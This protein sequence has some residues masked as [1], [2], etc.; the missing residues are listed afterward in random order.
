MGRVKEIQTV[1]DN[2]THDMVAI[3][4]CGQ[5]LIDEVREAGELVGVSDYF[6]DQYV[7][8]LDVSNLK[9]E[10]YDE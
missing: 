8:N 4:L 1:L 6:I 5:P 3:G 7:K 2:I 10:M 9:E